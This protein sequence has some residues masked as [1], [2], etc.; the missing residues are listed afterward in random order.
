MESA[1]PVSARSVIGVGL[2]VGF[3]LYT[4][5]LSCRR[6]LRSPLYSIILL[7]HG[8]RMSIFSLVMQLL[9]LATNIGGKAGDCLGVLSNAFEGESLATVIGAQFMYI[10][11]LLIRL[12]YV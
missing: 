11:R 8:N 12:N 5:S 7:G 3:P 1:V 2:N 9:I 10:L 4:G 6:L